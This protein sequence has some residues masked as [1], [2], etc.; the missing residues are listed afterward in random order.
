MKIL[1]QKNIYSRNLN[2]LAIKTNEINVFNKTNGI[3]KES[4]DTILQLINNNQNL[5]FYSSSEEEKSNN[6]N[7]ENLLSKTKNGFEDRLIS[8]STG[9]FNLKTKN[10][11][12]NKNIITTTYNPI[13]TK[14]N[15]LLKSITTFSNHKKRNQYRLSSNFCYFNNNK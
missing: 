11:I 3:S 2:K 15:K 10:D 9:P 7:D 8:Q 6:K 1:K 12:L 13:K 5:S 4:N 14:D